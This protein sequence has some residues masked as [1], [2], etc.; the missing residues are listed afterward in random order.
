MYKSLYRQLQQYADPE[1]C[2]YLC[3]ENNEIWQEVLGFIP[4]DRGGLPGMLDR[5]VN[6][7]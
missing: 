2:I 4:D 6:K 5:A 3:M 7:F 1:T